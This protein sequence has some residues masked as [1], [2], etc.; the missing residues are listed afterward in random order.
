MR[1]L[2]LRNQQSP[3][4]IVMLTAA[5][6]DLHT[7]HPGRFVTDVR[8]PCPALWEGN[9]LI[10]PLNEDDPSVET[11][12]CQYPLVHSSNQLPYHFIHAFRMF[13][14]DALQVRIPAGPFRGDIRLRHD[15]RSWMSQVEERNGLG[16]RYWIVVAGGKYDYTAKWWPKES[17]QEVVRLLRDEVLFVQVGANEH[18]HPPLEGV[19]DLRGRT[20]LRQLVRLVYH[21]D[22]IL[23]PV[24]V[25]MHLAAAVES[26]PGGPRLRPC[27]VVAGGREA[28]HWEAYPGH[29]FLHT[30]GA[31]PCCAEGGCWKSRIV[32]LG[33][34]DPKDHPEHLC[35]DVR[36]G[37][38]HCMELITPEVVVRAIRLYSRGN[39]AD[40][41]A[42]RRAM[43]T[44]NNSRPQNGAVLQFV[45]DGPWMSLIRERGRAL[46]ARPP[47]SEKASEVG[48]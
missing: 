32:P 9:P 7:A 48:E 6:R 29:Q 20:D 22:G 2:I 24:T 38:Q 45:P 41:Q 4:D 34:G 31:L 19:L 15:E 43:E 26:K 30:V 27:V 5:V 13:L 47:A 11:I 25:H 36:N 40:A 21:A 16:A 35:V 37:V 28:P 44:L 14:E 39:G 46:N 1:K 42:A 17:F 8:T 3:G 10:T 33:D 18:F 23:C 12:E